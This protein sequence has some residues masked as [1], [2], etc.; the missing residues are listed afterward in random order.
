MLGCRPGLASLKGSILDHP[1]PWSWLSGSVLTRVPWG[2][3]TWHRLGTFSSSPCGGA[4]GD[5]GER[6]LDLLQAKG[7]PHP[8]TSQPCGLGARSSPCSPCDRAQKVDTLSGRASSLDQQINKAGHQKGVAHPRAGAVQDRQSH[9]PPFWPGDSGHQGHR[10][11]GTRTFYG[12]A[13]ALR[14]LHMAPA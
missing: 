3:D 8:R 5:C 13:C 2:T 10:C 4:A 12:V 11:L 7:R 1:C 9:G 14:G 6:L